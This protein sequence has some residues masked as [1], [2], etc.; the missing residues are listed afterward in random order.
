ML[1]LIS[2]SSIPQQLDQVLRAGLRLFPLDLRGKSVVLRPNLA[3]YM[4]G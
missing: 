3:D 1:E 4:P 2:P